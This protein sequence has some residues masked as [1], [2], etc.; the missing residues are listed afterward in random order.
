MCIKNQKIN[1]TGC[2]HN[3]KKKHKIK[4]MPD[5]GGEARGKPEHDSADMRQENSKNILF[6]NKF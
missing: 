4:H 3:Q 6:K 2:E 5:F 1:K